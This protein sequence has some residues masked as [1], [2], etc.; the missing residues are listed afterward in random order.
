ME[1]PLGSPMRGS[2]WASALRSA[3]PLPA[4]V[5]DLAVSISSSSSSLPNWIPY[6]SFFLFHLFTNFAPP[7]LCLYSSQISSLIL[8]TFSLSVHFCYTQKLMFLTLSPRQFYHYSWLN[9]I[10]FLPCGSCWLHFIY[11]TYFLTK[12]SHFRLGSAAY[13]NSN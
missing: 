11:I 5:P 12:I 10:A 6:S 4:D 7:F 13:Y 1:R 8:V 9:E 3:S 2:Q